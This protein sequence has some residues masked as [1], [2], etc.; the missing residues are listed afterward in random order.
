MCT[1]MRKPAAFAIAVTLVAWA[2]AFAL[3]QNPARDRTA[4]I[5]SEPEPAVGT[6]R[7]P[8]AI[9]RPPTARELAQM[10]ISI[11][12]D[13]AELPQGSGSATQ[14]ALVFT[15]RA[16]STCHGPTGTE[17]P[18]NELV[19]GEPTA[20]S[21]YFPIVYWPYAT[22]I[23]DFIHRAM[24]YDRPWTP[25]GGRGVRAHG[26]SP[27]PQQHHPGRR[28]DGRQEPAKGSD[29]AQGSL[30]TAGRTV[31]A[32]WEGTLRQGAALAR[33]ALLCASDGC[34]LAQTSRSIRGAKAPDAASGVAPPASFL[35]SCRFPSRRHMRSSTRILHGVLAVV[36]GAGWTVVTTAQQHQSHTPGVSGLPHGV[37]FFC[38]EPYSREQIQRGVVGSGNLV[39]RHASCGER[40][41]DHRR[42]SCDHLRRGIRRDTG[43]H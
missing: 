35:S 25:H 16:C 26:V 31:E 15:Q 30:Q 32:G 40:Q 34:L 7:G 22:M 23:W 37:P 19:G 14:G 21:S 6:G 43:L 18:A 33:A 29:A 41:G 8:N 28:R 3:A 17:G 5:L 12:P 24:P 1:N 11:G 36:F 20:S 10:D 13:G 39:H 4:P 9:G 42:G 27:L 38:A 2:G